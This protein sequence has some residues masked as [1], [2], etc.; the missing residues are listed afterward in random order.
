[1]RESNGGEAGQRVDEDE[2]EEAGEQHEGVLTAQEP[3][4]VNTWGGEGKGGEGAKGET[5]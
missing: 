3:G 4:G 1:M 5:L 2:R